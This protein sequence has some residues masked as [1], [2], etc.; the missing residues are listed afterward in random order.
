MRVLTAVTYSGFIFL[1]EISI[2]KATVRSDPLEFGELDEP[3]PGAR[4]RAVVLRPSPEI[5]NPDA[6]IGICEESWP[7]IAMLRVARSIGA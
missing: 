3:A 6:R 5:M 2:W 4:R 7:V 1:D